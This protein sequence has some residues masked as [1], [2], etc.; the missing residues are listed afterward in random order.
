MIQNI[1]KTTWVLLDNTFLLV[2]HKQ[3]TTCKQLAMKK[4]QALLLFLFRMHSVVCFHIKGGL[5][6]ALLVLSCVHQ[7]CDPGASSDPGSSSVFLRPW[8]RLA[9]G[10][11]RGAA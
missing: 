3:S 1:N 6:S 10:N 2:V 9:P 8:H 4:T 11:E 5:S 7:R